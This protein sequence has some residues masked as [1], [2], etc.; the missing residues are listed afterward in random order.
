MGDGT[1]EAASD[2]RHERFEQFDL[3]DFLEHAQCGATDVL[4]WVLL[5]AGLALVN[6]T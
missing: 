6:D 3:F 4:V 1:Y 5:W 2:G